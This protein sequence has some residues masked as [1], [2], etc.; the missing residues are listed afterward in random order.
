MLTPSGIGIFSTPA[1]SPDGAWLAYVAKGQLRL[2]SPDGMHER[3]LAPV[4]SESV[5]WS[6][7]SQ[8]IYTAQQTDDGGFEVL[9]INASSGAVQARHSVKSPG[10]YLGT[11]TTPGQRFTLG[12]DGNSFLASVIRFRTDLWILENFAP[13]RQWLKWFYR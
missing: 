1:W 11:Q 2:I 3:A 7:N 6:R 5:V 9:A 8:T 4:H 10:V 13:Q 12:P